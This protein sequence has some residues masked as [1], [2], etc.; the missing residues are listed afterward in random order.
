AGSGTLFLDEIAEIPL[1][2]QAKLLRVL[3]ERTFERVG[4]AKP[5]PLAARVIAAT[6]RDLAAMVR[7]G[8]FREDLFYRLNVVQIALPPLR[9]RTDDIPKLVEGLLLKI[10][11]ELHRKVRLVTND[12]MD[13]LV[14][15]PWPGNVRELENALTRAVVLAKGET[16]DVRLLAEAPA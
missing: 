5:L 14:R 8:T 9:E 10:N 1:D 16:L 2:L 13:A 6:H 11:R 7:A 15:Y 4:D 12:A 3:Q